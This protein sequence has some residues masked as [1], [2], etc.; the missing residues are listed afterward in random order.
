MRHFKIKTGYR[1]DEFIPITEDELQTAL[2][3]FLTDSKGVFKNGV[4]RGKDIIGIME[5]WHKEMGWNQGY[6]L[7][8]EDFE[9]IKN[10]CGH[11]VGYLAEAKMKVL[12]KLQGGKMKQIA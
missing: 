10:K 5:N 9:E 12:E 6:K 4:V 8:P 3:C 2:H 11:Y 7:L 1:D